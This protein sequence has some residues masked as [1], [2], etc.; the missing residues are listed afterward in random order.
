MDTIENNESPV[1][2]DGATSSP[3]TDSQVNTQTEEST[4]GVSDAQ[5]VEESGTLLAGKYKSPV[6]LEK[7]YKELEGKLGELG[8]KASAAD[9]LQE[10]FGVTPEQLQ[11]QIEQMETQKQQERYKNDPMAPVVDEINQLK[12]IVERQEQEKAYANEERELDKFLKENPGYAP[13][14]DKILKLGLTSEQDKP[15]EEIAREWF[16]ETRAQG[17]QD[18]Y[19]KIE[20]KQQTQSSGVQSAPNK[21]FSLEDMKGMSAAELEKILP[22]AQK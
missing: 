12:Q 22:H 10:K 7:A 2:S 19:K 15:Y 4:E 17:Q 14:R 21:T 1:G 11:A 5:K 16:G 6:E 9:L 8:Q 13:N 20:T 18:A 3:D